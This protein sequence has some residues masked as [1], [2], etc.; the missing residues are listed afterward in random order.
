MVCNATRLAGSVGHALLACLA[1]GW[2]RSGRLAVLVGLA[3]L[4]VSPLPGAASETVLV[5]RSRLAEA[6]MALRFGD[7]ER[8]IQLIEEELARG[9][10]RRSDVAKALSNLCA[11][12]ILIGEYDTAVVHC[13]RSLEIVQTN[14]R[15]FNNRASAFLGQ[16]RLD[17]AIADLGRGL[18][19]RPDSAM[20]RRSLE[21]AHERERRGLVDPLGAGATLRAHDPT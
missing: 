9:I 1:I 18:E 2:R 14:W 20:M 15:A 10:E 21:N 5:E 19:L 6:S 8:G 7:A 3:G 12:Y 11:G 13:D 4:V 17:E 16:G